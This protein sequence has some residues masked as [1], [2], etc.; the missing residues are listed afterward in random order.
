MELQMNKEKDINLNSLEDDFSVVACVNGYVL[1]VSGK[2]ARGE[3]RR[4]KYLLPSVDEL[5]EFIRM[6]DGKFEA[7]G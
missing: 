5:V 2:D 3:Y 6:A 4:L 1:D 7:R